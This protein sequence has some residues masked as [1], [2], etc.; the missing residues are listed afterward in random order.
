MTDTDIFKGLQSILIDKLQVASERVIPSARLKED[1]DADS[2]GAMEIAMSVEDLYDIE[3]LDEELHALVTVSD[4]I[5]LAKSKLV[6]PEKT[7][8]SPVE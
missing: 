6:V 7:E 8:G 1:L 4:I 3:I 2:L 5:E